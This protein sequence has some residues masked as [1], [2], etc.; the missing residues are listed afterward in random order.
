MEM[1]IIALVAIAAFAAVLVPLFRRGDRSAAA[2]REFDDAPRAEPPPRQAPPPRNRP[3]REHGAAPL[4]DA[5][6][7]AGEGIVPPMAAGPAT[8][9]AP[10]AATGP[11]A[12]AEPTL[13]DAAARAGGSTAPSDRVEREV[14]RYREALRAGTLCRKCGEANPQGSRFCG[15]CGADLAGRADDQEFA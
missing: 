12:P 13:P 10:T 2:R 11:D 6:P 7:A 4:A 8:P 3:R 5:D 15:D 14:A 9:V 1:L